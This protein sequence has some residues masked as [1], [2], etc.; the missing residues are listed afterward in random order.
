MSASGAETL[1]LESILEV[2]LPC[3]VESSSAVEQE[4]LGASGA[5]V[6]HILTDESALF[7]PEGWGWGKI[8]PTTLL[9]ALY[10]FIPSNGPDQGLVHTICCPLDTTTTPLAK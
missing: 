10:I 8:M 3:L 1:V 5:R 6:L 2:F 7:Q 4:G 9:L